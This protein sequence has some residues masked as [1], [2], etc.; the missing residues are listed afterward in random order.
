MFPRHLYVQMC[1]V[2][3]FIGTPCFCNFNN[4]YHRGF[5][6][7]RLDI[8]EPHSIKTIFSY[9]CLS[10]DKASFKSNLFFPMWKPLLHKRDQTR[11]VDQ[12][13]Q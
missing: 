3:I 10:H 8:S 6:E 2:Y 4:I 12:Q 1:L 13:L 7:G 9:F 11:K 5:G